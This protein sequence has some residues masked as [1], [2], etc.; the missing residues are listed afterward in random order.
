MF[1]S[2]EYY[3]WR[4]FI[5]REQNVA[6]K[7]TML[8]YEP[9]YVMGWSESGIQF[10]WSLL[11]IWP[12]CP[13][14]GNWICLLPNLKASCRVPRL[15]SMA[16]STTEVCVQICFFWFSL[17]MILWNCHQFAHN[18]GLP[19]SRQQTQIQPDSVLCRSQPYFAFL[20]WNSTSNF[21]YLFFTML[22]FTWVQ[23]KCAVVSPSSS[24]FR[25]LVRKE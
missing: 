6:F 4:I 12:D 17:V 19:N 13:N 22:T 3:S 8:D 25:E 20:S 1:P 5:Q 21:F 24:T 16:I 2:S 15:H 18:W 11:L 14:A 10:C 7:I 23:T 9:E